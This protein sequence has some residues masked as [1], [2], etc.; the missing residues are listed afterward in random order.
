MSKNRF[1]SHQ[2]LSF[3]ALLFCLFPSPSPA[4]VSTHNAPHWLRL[5]HPGPYMS[6]GE[7]AS[8]P[9]RSDTT[10]TIPNRPPLYTSLVVSVSTPNRHHHEH[11]FFFQ[12]TFGFVAAANLYRQ[13]GG[14]ASSPTD[15]IS[16]PALHV[17]PVLQTVPPGSRTHPA[18]P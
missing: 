4:R 8:P 18:P 7:A 5:L 12:P 3:L 16:T 6:C 13:E 1:C 15:D 17:Q 11:N 14:A 2:V 10:R 9:S